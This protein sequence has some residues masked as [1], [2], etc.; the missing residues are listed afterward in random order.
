MK[1]PFNIMPGTVIRGKW[2]KKEYTVIRELGRGANGIVYLADRNGKKVAVKMSDQSVNISSET[3][4][5]KSFQKARG[6]SLGPSLL[7]IDDWTYGSRQMSFYVMEYI[8]GWDL[9][10]F[11]KRKGKNWLPVLILQLLSDLDNLHRQGWVFEDLKPENLIVT[12]MPVKVRC[13]DFGGATLQGRAVKEFTEFYDRG[14]WGL[15]SRKAEPSYDL[16][17][18]AMII[19]HVFCLDR[20]EKKEGGIGQLKSV[21]EQKEGLQRYQPVLLKALKGRYTRAEEMRKDLL[22]IV[23]PKTTSLTMTDRTG[24]RTPKSRIARNKDR[25]KGRTYGMLET[26]VILFIICMIYALYIFEQLL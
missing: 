18:V 17:A 1:S 4:V 8:R 15:G 5:L 21:I 14:Y 11:I 23:Y 26:L 3:N 6:V 25:R 12:D 20:F 9:L 19:I 24:I 13:I 7:D 16:F 22:K 2:N 10:T